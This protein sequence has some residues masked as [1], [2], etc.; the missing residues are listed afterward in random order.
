MSKGN[1]I[2][3]EWRK[4]PADGH[5]VSVNPAKPEEIID[6]LDVSLTAVDEAVDAAT[7]AW[8]SWRLLSFDQR[9][10]FL[11]ELK[12]RITKNAAAL[13]QAITRDSGKALWEAHTEVAALRGKIDITLADGRAD[14]AEHKLADGSFVRHRPHGPMAVIGPFNFPLSL[15]HGH[16]V[17]GLLAGNTIVLKPS[18]Q[19][20]YVAEKYAELFDHFPKGVFNLVQGAGDIGEKV[21]THPGIHGVLFTGSYKVGRA[22]TLACIDQAHK[23]LVLEMGGKNA[24][25][26]SEECDW[27][28]ALYETCFSAF[29]TTGQRCTA[30]SRLILVGSADFAERFSNEVVRVASALSIGDPLAP[31]TF[32]GPLVSARARDGFVAATTELASACEVLLAARAPEGFF[33][34][35]QIV[36]AGVSVSGAG[37][38]AVGARFLRE[39][40][41]GPQLSIFHARDRDEAISIANDTDYG[42]AMSVFCRERAEFERYLE[43]SRV[44][45]L[46]WNKGTVGATGKLPFGGIGKSGNF[47][48][49]GLY[50]GR[51]CTYPV[52]TVIGE[53]LPKADAM[54]PGFPTL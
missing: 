25:V 29:V 40:I 44:G 47:R 30:S 32:M 39:E 15:S 12:D 3:G 46:N 53:A 34:S 35:P 27:K 19:T 38:G 52:A 8:H 49:A 50:S 48:P 1:W 5:L 26:V 43:L 6:E 45:I 54:P 33:V 31:T 9:A 41:F 36:R 18:E 17:P 11:L 23:I 2:A 4:P 16:I 13:A 22:L 10:T 37:S 24:T 42:L 51:S 7:S 20:P 21:A 28:L 14:I